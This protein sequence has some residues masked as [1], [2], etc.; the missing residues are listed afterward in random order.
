MA[1]EGS[2]QAMV[3]MG[4][5]SMVQILPTLRTASSSLRDVTPER[6]RCLFDDET[7]LP[8]TAEYSSDVC[9]LECEA[10]KIWRACS[11]RPLNFPRI[12]G[13][14]G[15]FCGLNKLACLA[16][17]HEEKH[18]YMVKSQVPSN[19]LPVEPAPAD[20]LSQEKYQSCGCMAQCT[21]VDYELETTTSNFGAS[22]WVRRNFYKNL[23]ATNRSL[24][25]VYF[26]SQ[27][28]PKFI[29]DLVSNNVQLMSSC[30]GIFSLFL[31]CSFMSAVEVVYFFTV[32]LWL[33]V[34]GEGANPPTTAGPPGISPN[35]TPTTVS[36]VAKR[37]KDDVWGW[38]SEKPIRPR[39]F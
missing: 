17:Y 37:P 31:G 19:K 7:I 39:V 22:R 9:L 12:S 30:G 32:R 3:S 14:R 13:V 5:E 18:E 10:S 27:T 1:T 34:R 23:N 33:L 11:C 26:D 15:R 29:N 36:H 6:R 38:G 35:D 25:H 21:S 2:S 28:A 16:K 24:L 4:K 8:D 20:A